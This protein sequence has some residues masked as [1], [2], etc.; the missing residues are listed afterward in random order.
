MAETQYVDHLHCHYRAVEEQLKQKQS[1][2]LDTMTNGAGK[3]HPTTWKRRMIEHTRMRRKTD[4]NSRRLAWDLG[5]K[6]KRKLDQIDQPTPKRKKRNQSDMVRDNN[7]IP[8][9]VTPLMPPPGRP[10]MP[11]QLQTHPQLR[12]R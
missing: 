3:G 11:P 10:V 7:N 8:P 9:P 2:L 1:I 12:R 5:E 6:K 4:D